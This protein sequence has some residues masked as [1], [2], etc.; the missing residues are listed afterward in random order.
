MGDL[1]L[2]A[3]VDSVVLGDRV[4]SGEVRR[5]LFR[6]ALPVDGALSMPISASSN[7]AGN[8]TMLPD[9]DC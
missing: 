9:F 4:V 1:V 7:I 2:R 8:T 5:V 3:R 6:P